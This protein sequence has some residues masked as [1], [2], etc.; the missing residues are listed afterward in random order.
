MESKEGETITQAADVVS[1]ASSPA[2]A[3]DEILSA[4][5]QLLRAQG[6]KGEL[7]RQFSSFAALSMGFVIT[8][9]WIGY[10]AT[11][12]TPLWTG[13]G[14]MVFFGVIVAAIACFIISMWAPQ[15]TPSPRAKTQLSSQREQRD[16]Q[17]P[18]HAIF[19]LLGSLL[20]RCSSL[21]AG[22]AELASAFPSSGGQY[23]FAFMVASPKSRALAAFVMGWMSTLAWVL[24]ASSAVV[25][26]GESSLSLLTPP[27]H[28]ANQ[29]R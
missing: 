16:N 17:I 10:S 14:P 18:G 29:R 20:M 5:E 12:V 2:S 4:D 19:Y 1:P 11:F 22:L 7:P 24:T 26:C 9:S 13:G 8:N 28:C 3:S 23:H 25:Y 6:H 21:A 27:C 15:T